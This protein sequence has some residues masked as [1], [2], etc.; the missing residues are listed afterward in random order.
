[1][2]SYTVLP[3]ATTGDQTNAGVRRDDRHEQATALDLPADQRIPGIASAKLALVEP[4]LD[5]RGT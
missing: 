2:Q 3:P 1:V 5:T 4:H